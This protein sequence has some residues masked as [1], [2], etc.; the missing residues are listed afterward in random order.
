MAWKL[1]E[2]G[3][4]VMPIHHPS[5]IIEIAIGDIWALDLKGVSLNYHL[6][7]RKTQPTTD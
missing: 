5:M 4:V 7:G 6:D 3:G 1:D 2:M